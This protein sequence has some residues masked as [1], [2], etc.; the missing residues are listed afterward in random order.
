MLNLLLA[1]LSSA[2]IAIVMRLGEEKIRNNMGMFVSNY[3]VCSLLSFAYMDRQSNVGSSGGIGIVLL[4]GIAAGVLYLGNF[5]LLQ[6]NI[7][8]NGM[9]LASTFMKLGVLVP[10]IMAIIVFKEQPKIVQIAGIV[11]AVT[12]ILVINLEK[13]DGSKAGNKLMLIVILLFSGITD[14]MANIFDKK[15]NVAFK[16]FYLLFTFGAALVCAFVLWFR[17]NESFCKWD[18]LFGILVGVP[19]YYSSRFLLSALH[20]LP[21]VVV[22]PG[23]SVGSIVLVTLAG[24]FLFNEKLSKRKIAALALILAALVLLNI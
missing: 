15:I 4:L 9:V 1:V 12:A 8:L 3:L 5:V 6:K 22:Y 13:S 18:I 14:S 20:D 24:V 2:S 21:A 19:N 17:N 11:F 23:F 7:Q 10:T 16:D